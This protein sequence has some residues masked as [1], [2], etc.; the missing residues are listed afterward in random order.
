MDQDL[1]ISLAVRAMEL[2]LKVA[3]PLLLV[4]LVVGL[5]V[6]L[7]QAVTQIQEQTLTFIPKILAT[8]A[9]HRHRRAVDARP[10]PQLHAETST[11]RS[12]TW[13][14]DA[15]CRPAS[16]SPSSASS[17]SSASSS[18][19][20]ASSPLFVLAPLFSSKMIPARVRGIVAVALAIGLSPVVAQGAKLPDRRR[21]DLGGPGRQGAARRRRLRLRAR[22]RSSPRSQVA[23]SLLDTLI[24]FSFGGLVDPITGNQS[25][26]LAQVYCADRAS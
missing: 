18:C 14:A 9:V 16:S 26:V 1:V 4:G 24:G 7:F 3:L 25:A 8:A 22:R 6:S 12:R 17:R 10:A 2:A 5:I 11:R 20:R 15:E 21:G 23:G 13:S 19:W